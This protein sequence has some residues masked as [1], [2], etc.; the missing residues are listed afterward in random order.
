V[1]NDDQT[2]TKDSL[3][4]LESDLLTQVGPLD[5]FTPADAARLLS[6]AQGRY[7]WQVLAR[8]RAKGWIERIRPGVYAVVPLSSGAHRTPQLHE[9]LV[10]MKLVQPAAIAYLSALSHHGMTEQLPALVY[11][12]TDHRVARPK[13]QS[14]GISFRIVAQ[15]PQCYFGLGQEWINEQPFTITNLEKTL[16]DGLTLPE[17]VGGV[18]TVVQALSRY[19][20]RVDEDRLYAYALRLDVSAVVKRLGLLLETLQIGH[21]ER[22]R[23]SGRLATGFPSLDPTLP[24]KGIHNRRWGLLVNANVRL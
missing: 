16:I 24:A 14:L 2:I 23:Q 17:Y 10:A 12:A 13:R 11:V 20:D 22:L 7:V 21:P 5:T 8:L 19:W 1:I 9:F 15:R 3:G 4:K 18:G 6:P